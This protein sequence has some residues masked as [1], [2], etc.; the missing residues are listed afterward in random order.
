M[1]ELD[2]EIA[3]LKEEVDLLEK[4]IDEILEKVKLKED[5]RQAAGVIKILEDEFERAGMDKYDALQ[6]MVM[7]ACK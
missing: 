6:L 7:M 1:N 2:I 5:A 3:E 4:R